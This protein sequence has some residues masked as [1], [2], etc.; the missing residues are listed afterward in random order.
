MKVRQV[1]VILTLLVLIKF[2]FESDEEPNNDNL[3][4]WRWRLQR[5]AC[6]L[7]QQAKDFC[8]GS[9]KTEW[10]CELQG[11]DRKRGEGRFVKVE[12]LSASQ[13]ERSKAKSGRTSLQDENAIVTEG[14]LLIPA[15]AQPEFASV[16]PRGPKNKKQP[17]EWQRREYWCNRRSNGCGKFNE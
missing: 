4:P 16:Q 3:R 9:V 11:A 15:D 2:V 5:E 10:E 12:G 13:L 1:L 8:D 6:I 17:Q 14:K 7:V